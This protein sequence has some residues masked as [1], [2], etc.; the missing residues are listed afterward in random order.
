MILLVFHE[1]LG[2]RLGFLLNRHNGRYACGNKPILQIHCW[3]RGGLFGKLV[4]DHYWFSGWD[5]TRSAQEF[6]LL[7]ALIEAGVET[8]AVW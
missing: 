4:N 2:T 7:L 5:N 1:M 3:R 8:F 6:Q